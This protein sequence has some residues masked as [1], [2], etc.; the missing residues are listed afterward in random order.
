MTRDYVRGGDGRW[1]AV[2]QRC[3]QVAQ[4]AWIDGAMHFVMLLRELRRSV[5]RKM[6]ST[7]LLRKN[8]Q[9]SQ[10]QM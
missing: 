9:Q 3:E 6:R 7:Y 4:F 2:S 5:G 1:Q 10:Q 8:Q